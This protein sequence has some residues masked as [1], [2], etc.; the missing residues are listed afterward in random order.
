MSKFCLNERH[1]ANYFFAYDTVIYFV[2]H[3]SINQGA[4]DFIFK[5]LQKWFSG[6]KLRFNMNKT[7]HVY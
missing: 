5:T 4:F 6:A 2:Y 3:A 7:V 1:D